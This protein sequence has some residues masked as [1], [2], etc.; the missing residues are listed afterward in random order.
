MLKRHAPDNIYKILIG[1]KIEMPGL[2]QVDYEIA[3]K[4]AVENNMKYY[5]TSGLSEGN[6]KYIL[7]EMAW[8]IL[9]NKEKNGLILCLFSKK[10]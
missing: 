9:Q 4:F 5:E 8:G 2:R 6:D 7:P 3:N 10:S 1:N